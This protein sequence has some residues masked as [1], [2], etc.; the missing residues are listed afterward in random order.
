MVGK[1]EV[2]GSN[3]RQAPYLIARSEVCSSDCLNATQR[4]I[5]DAFRMF[6]GWILLCSYKD[7]E[8]AHTIFYYRFNNLHITFQ[9]KSL[10]SDAYKPIN[11][12]TR[13]DFDQKWL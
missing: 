2:M 4:Y 9:E 8:K 3:I 5:H 6:A 10:P 11:A 12:E 1:E 7:C 13:K